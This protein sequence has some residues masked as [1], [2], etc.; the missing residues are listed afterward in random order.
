MEELHRVLRTEGILAIHDGMKDEVL[1][2][3][4][5]L[6]SLVGRDDKLL[7]FEKVS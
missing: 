3:T 7:R 4:T 5:G 2:Y 1:D 6:F